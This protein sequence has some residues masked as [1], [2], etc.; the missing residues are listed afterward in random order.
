MFSSFIV[1]ENLLYKSG[2]LIPHRS[3]GME[4]YMKKIWMLLELSSLKKENK[5]IVFVTSSIILSVCLGAILWLLIGRLFLPQL[6]W[7]LCFMGYPGV[8]VGF[9]GS[10][11]YLYNNEFTGT[12]NVE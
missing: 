8:V 6:I 2:L 1:R 5:N 10:T 11:F 4:A 3:G 12:K 7:L 9:F